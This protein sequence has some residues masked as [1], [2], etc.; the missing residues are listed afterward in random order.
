MDARRTLILLAALALPAARG[1][2]KDELAEAPTGRIAEKPVDCLD[3]YD[4]QSVRVV[5]GQAII[6]GVY[7]KLYVNR[8]QDG[9]DRLRWNDVLVTR[10]EAGHLCRNDP[11]TLVD[12]V[13]RSEHAFIILGQ[14]TPY[15]KPR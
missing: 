9:A 11:I 15:A 4:S 7:G 14:F 3:P 1:P 10:V 6:Y 12:P 5:P 2:A 13:T 8:P